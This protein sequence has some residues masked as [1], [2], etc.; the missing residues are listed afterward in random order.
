[1]A[2][3][4]SFRYHTANGSRCDHPDGCAGS[5]WMYSVR[6]VGRNR[7][8]RGFVTRKEADA[9]LA[10]LLASVVTEEY[11]EPT[12]ET[13]S[14]WADQWL[15]SI[16]RDVEPSTLRNYEWYLRKYVLPP[17]GRKKLTELTPEH[18]EDVYA[19]MAETVGAT[20]IR[21]AH[22]VAGTCSTP[23]SSASGSARTR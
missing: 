19:K 9:A 12:K 3:G 2:K 6:I 11:V 1:M 22:A 14:G 16:S 23:P 18:F 17:L 20:T 10:Q 7:V 15:S 4:S 5:R 13:L 8:Q 21:T